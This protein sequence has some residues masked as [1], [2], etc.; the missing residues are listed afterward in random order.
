MRFRTTTIDAAAQDLRAALEQ[1]PDLDVVLCL[2]DGWRIGT[3][4]V[5]A[6]DGTVHVGH[7]VA[8][9]GDEVRLFGD[10]PPERPARAMHVPHFRADGT[11]SRPREPRPAIACLRCGGACYRPHSHGGT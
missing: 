4:S 3:R 8:V 1:R 5:P 11:L 9:R 2:L 6:D 7:L 10:E